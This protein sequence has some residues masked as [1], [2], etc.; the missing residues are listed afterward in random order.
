LRTQKY[1]TRGPAATD[2]ASRAHQP[3]RE[4][5][6]STRA[7][8]HARHRWNRSAAATAR[9]RAVAGAGA[10]TLHSPADW[11][12]V[13][14]HRQLAVHSNWTVG[15]SPREALNMV[16]SLLLI[17]TVRVACRSA[18]LRSQPSVLPFYNLS[19]SILHFSPA[20]RSRTTVPLQIAPR[21]RRP[22]PP[23]AS[24]DSGWPQT[25]PPAPTPIMPP[26]S[27]PT[28]KRCS[29]PRGSSERTPGCRGCNPPPRREAPPPA[30]QRMRGG[31]RAWEIR[32]LLLGP[33][34]KWHGRSATSPPPIPALAP[35]MEGPPK[36]LGRRGHG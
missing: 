17:K 2:I 27:D 16:L 18:I 36:G 12:V 30:T 10:P 9:R 20:P 25:P 1:R 33:R 11:F 15:A 3:I 34:Q 6:T 32:H 28:R 4:S 21:N 26:S 24:L 29:P 23:L 31:R 8:A 22:R 5:S 14:V 19:R 35:D 13:P 7:I